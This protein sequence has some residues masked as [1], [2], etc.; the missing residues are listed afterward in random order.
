[1]VGSFLFGWPI[2]PI[3]MGELLV[4]GRVNY[5]I[6]GESNKQQIYGTCLGISLKIAVIF[7]DPWFSASTL[8]RDKS[9][10]TPRTCRHTKVSPSKRVCNMKNMNLFCSNSWFES[11]KKGCEFSKHVTTILKYH[12]Q[13]PSQGRMEHAV[14]WMGGLWPSISTN[15]HLKT[16][17]VFLVMLLLVFGFDIPR[18]CERWKSMR[19]GQFLKARWQFIR[20]TCRWHIL[21]YIILPGGR[22]SF[23]NWVIRPL[24]LCR[25]GK[26]KNCLW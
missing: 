15:H 11:Q 5:P 2:W 21:Q 1:M 23:T 13:L 24:W 26:G 4:L 20:T 6:L 8:C 22:V 3:F 9:Y 12:P 25:N 18:S 10:P 16:W 14:S 17:Q 7:H 19:I